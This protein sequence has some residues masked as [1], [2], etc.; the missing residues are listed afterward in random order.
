MHAHNPLRRGVETE[1]V[2]AALRYMIGA[3]AVTGQIITI[4]GGQRFLGL[5]R[6]VQFLGGE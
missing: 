3:T 2:V 4:D 1:D 6:D 5:E